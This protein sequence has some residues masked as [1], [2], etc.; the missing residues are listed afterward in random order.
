MSSTEVI[1]D[2]MEK[3]RVEL[4]NVNQQIGIISECIEIQEKIL[5]NASVIKSDVCA[6]RTLKE[7]E[8]DLLIKM[9]NHIHNACR[10]A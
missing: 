7:H 2:Q 5:A 3:M 1:Q 9:I 4:A 6:D 8:Y 10:R